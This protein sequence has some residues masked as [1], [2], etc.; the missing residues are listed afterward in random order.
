MVMGV[1]PQHRHFHH[2][3]VAVSL[4]TMMTEEWRRKVKNMP[5]FRPIILFKIF[6]DQVLLKKKQIRKKGPKK[7]KIK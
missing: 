2:R 7:L 4:P 3:S 1:V 6:L 5:K